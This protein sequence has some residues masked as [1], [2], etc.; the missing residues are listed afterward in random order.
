M[1]VREVRLVAGWGSGGR[2]P[3]VESREAEF[4]RAGAPGV[5]LP[6][7]VRHVGGVPGGGAGG[8]PFREVP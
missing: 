1:R 5:V 6:R 3:G 8:S 4:R 2:G 7:G